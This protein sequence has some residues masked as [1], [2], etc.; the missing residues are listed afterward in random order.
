MKYDIL[1]GISTLKYFSMTKQYLEFSNQ[2]FLHKYQRSNNITVSQL[3][4]AHMVDNDNIDIPH[5]IV[6]FRKKGI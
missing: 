6:A 2:A 1:Q 5:Y 3:G 4:G